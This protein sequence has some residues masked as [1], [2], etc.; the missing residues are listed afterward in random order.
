MFH[1]SNCYCEI[2][3]SPGLLS[4]RAFHEEIADM[5]KKECLRTV[6]ILSPDYLIS[7]WCGYEANLS[8]TNSPGR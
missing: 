5:I 3:P 4:D 6:V 2:D 7:T 1:H 8:F